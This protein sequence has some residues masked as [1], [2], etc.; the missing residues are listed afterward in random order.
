MYYFGE[1]SLIYNVKRNPPKDKFV[2]ENAH[3]PNIYFIVI[4][5]ALKKLRGNVDR[6]STKGFPHCLGTD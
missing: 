3:T 5:L 1:I 6:R 2:S 4:I